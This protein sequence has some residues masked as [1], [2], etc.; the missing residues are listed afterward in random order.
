MAQPTAKPAN[1]IKRSVSISC[2]LCAISVFLCVSVVN[3][4]SLTTETQRTTEFHRESS[5]PARRNFDVLAHQIKQTRPFK[6]G[7][8][9]DVDDCGRHQ[10]LPA[11]DHQLIEAK[12]RQGP[13]QPDV[14]EQKQDY[15]AEEIEHAEPR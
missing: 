12:T 14:E 5:Q 10:V 15:L 8:D 1:K 6:G 13:A 2:Y 3:K 4:P 11:K 9:H 7:R